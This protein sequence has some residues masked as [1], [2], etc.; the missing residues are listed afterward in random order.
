MSSHLLADVQDVCDRIAI[1]YAGELKVLGHVQ[2]L[3]QSTEETQL[4]TGRLSE[5]ALA[6]VKAALAR[7]AVDL[8][9]VSHPTATLE[10]LFLKT[11]AESRQRPG[12]RFVAEAP[13]AGAPRG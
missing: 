1:L 7:H 3:L 8:K 10:E 2:D 5:A 11:V 4:R 12:H 9:E 13:A 6:D